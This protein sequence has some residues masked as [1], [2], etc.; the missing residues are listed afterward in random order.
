MCIVN[1]S[2]YQIL[3]LFLLACLRAYTK[4][5]KRSLYH[6]V[7]LKLILFIIGVRRMAQHEVRF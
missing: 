3:A 5:E 1:Y 2:S 7:L 4:R 6:A